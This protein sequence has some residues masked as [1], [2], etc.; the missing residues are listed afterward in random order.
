MKS[1]SRTVRHLILASSLVAL[2]AFAEDAAK[3]AT[4]TGAA[5]A[6]AAGSAAASNK[7]E[8]PKSPYLQ[9]QQK[10]Q[11]HNKHKSEKNFDKKDNGKN[12]AESNPKS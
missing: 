1:I 10:Q 6:P 3:T 2:P 4:A 11:Q 5:V 9:Q 8:P 7:K 12:A